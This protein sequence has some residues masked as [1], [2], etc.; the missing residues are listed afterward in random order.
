MAEIVGVC[1]V[2]VAILMSKKA[3]MAEKIEMGSILA[4]T[5][6]FSGISPP[7]SAGASF[8]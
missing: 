6:Q 4:L 1:T 2:V 5:L 7:I 3:K 8:G